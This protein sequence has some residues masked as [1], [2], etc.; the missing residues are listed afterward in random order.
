MIRRTASYILLVSVYSLTWLIVAVGSVIP[1]RRWTPNGRILATG[2]IFNPNWYLSHITPLVRSG[3]KEVIL[4]IDEPQRPMEGV[5]FACPPKWLGKL[6]SR[7]GAKAVWVLYA[8][9][10]FR[11]DLFMG[12]NLVAGGCTA[13]A[14]GA[15]LGRPTCYQMTG[16][17]VVLSRLNI[18]TCD[19]RQNG[20]LRQKVHAR[21]ERLAVSLIRKFDL[22]VVRGRQAQAFLASYGIREGVTIITGSVKDNPQAVQD[23]RDIDLTFVGR[24]EP[25]KQVDQFI[26]IVA[27]V[28]RV[29][30]STRAVIVGDG[31]L[32][33]DMKAYAAQLDVKDRIEFLGKREDVETILARSKIFI[34]TS[35]SE[36]LSIA[37]AEAMAG[38]VVPVVPDVGELGD[39]VQNNVNGFLV[40]PNNVCEHTRRVLGLL[41]DEEQWSAFSE[42][43]KK[44]ARHLCSIGAV[45]ERWKW[46]LQ[47]TIL[48]ASGYGTGGS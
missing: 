31:V 28:S 5:R 15:L 25:I 43:A 40:G 34:L 23:T 2:S 9:I 6:I 37:M 39:L 21:I 22:V 35:M 14:A 17:H 18:N 32:M 36:G 10:R 16:T 44:A 29:M 20:R 4:V 41:K 3:I 8:G 42:E 45:T 38:G 12:Y 26:R 30:P 7:A 19:P 48:R 46:C 1:H 47:G 13:L 24:L 33:A 27:D 11:P